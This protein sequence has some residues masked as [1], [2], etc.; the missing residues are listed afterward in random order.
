FRAYFVD[1]IDIGDI[2][3]LAGLAGDAGLDAD[4]ARAW[5][6]AGSGR[7]AIEAEETRS[8]ALGVTGVPFFVF[9]QR[10]AV[11][12]AQPPEVLLDAME[13]ADAAMT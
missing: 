11:S 3:A 1:G 6:A 12:G 4:T 13:Q 5:L 8:R 10:L 7:T 2:D 9:N